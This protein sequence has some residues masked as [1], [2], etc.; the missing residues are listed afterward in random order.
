MVFIKKKIEKIKENLSETFS[1]K[2]LLI[3]YKNRFCVG[4]VRIKYISRASLLSWKHKFAN[5]VLKYMRE[6]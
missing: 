5:Q 3:C 4:I 1:L 2:I 6:C